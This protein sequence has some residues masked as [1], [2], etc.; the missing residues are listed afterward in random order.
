MFSLG[1]SYIG[2]LTNESLLIVQVSWGMPLCS[3]PVIIHHP[4]TPKA[5][6]PDT[7]FRM[8]CVLLVS[9]HLTVVALDTQWLA[10]DIHW[11]AVGS[12]NAKEQSSLATVSSPIA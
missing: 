6:F 4:V 11:I 8:L 2:E 5:H 10:I 3:P 1:Y 12:H 7:L 9:E